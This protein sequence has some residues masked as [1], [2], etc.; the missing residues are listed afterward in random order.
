MYQSKSFHLHS[1]GCY[2][3]WERSWVL[4]A[5]RSVWASRKVKG[6][7]W[8][9]LTVNMSIAGPIVTDNGNF[10]IDAPFGQEKMQDPSKVCPPLLVTCYHLHWLAQIL[11]QIKL[12][13]G[14]VEVGLF[15]GM[16]KAAYFG[17]Q[18]HPTWIFADPYWYMIQ[19]G[20]VTIR[21]ED[22]TTSHID[23]IDA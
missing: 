16:A 2:G 7:K 18:V 8:Y 4:R 21:R 15:C 12:L 20:T 22:G 19:D 9:C 6:F 5:L 14:V 11:A 10:V 3:S 23:A 1:P 17:N 13:T